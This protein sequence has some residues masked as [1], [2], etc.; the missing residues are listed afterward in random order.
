MTPDT[1]ATCPT[2]WS[3]PDTTEQVAQIVRLAAGPACRS[4][5]AAQGRGSPADRC[6]WPAAWWSV[7]SR[8]RRIIEINAEDRYAVVEAGVVN[9]DL[10]AA[11]APMGLYYAPDPSSQTVSTLGGNVAENAGGPH[12]L[13]YGLT[14]NHVLAL[15]VVL[16]D[17]QVVQMGSVAPDR[18]GYDLRGV[19]IGSEGM[20]GI[21]TKITVRLMPKPEDARTLV[22]IYD[23]LEDAGATV[24][25]LLKQGIMPAAA[26]IMDNLITRAD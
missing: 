12:C 8:L 13:L 24:T 7:T 17:G 5:H 21:V 9:V 11:V 26:E 22:A 14:S 15:E 6:L 1:T 10:T 20:L 3:C 23:S 4:C 2:R 18:P 19:V 25:D 16:A